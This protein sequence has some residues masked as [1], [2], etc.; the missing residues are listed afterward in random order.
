MQ[1]RGPTRVRGGGEARQ[2]GGARLLLFRFLSI[3]QT[4]IK[5]RLC[6]FSAGDTEM[7]KTDIPVKTDNN[8]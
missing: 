6:V 1:V 7:N 8:N 5:Y 3:R 2:R 4:S